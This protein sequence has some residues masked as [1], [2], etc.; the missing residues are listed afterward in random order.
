MVHEMSL[1]ADERFLIIAVEESD[2]SVGFYDS[3]DGSQVA[4]VGVG[5]WPHEIAMSPDRTL[6]YVTNFGVKDYDERIGKPGASISIID[7]EAKCEIDRLYTFRDLSEFKRFQSPHG[8]VVS[9]DGCTAYVNVESDDHI[10]L[11]DLTKPANEKRTPSDSWLLTSTTSNFDSLPDGKFPVP[12]GTHNM[13]LSPDEATLWVVS[14][15]GGVTEYCVATRKPMRSF[16]CNGAVRGLTYTRDHNYLIASASNEVCIVDPTT[17]RVVRRFSNLGI[18]QVLYS[19]PTPDGRYILSPAVWE[20]QLVRIDMHSGATERIIVG[21]DPI[22]VLTSPRFPDETYAYVTHGRSRYISIVD[23]ANF[24][25]VGRIETNGGPNGISWAPYSERPTR[26]KLVFGAC[27]PMSGG[28]AVEGQDL[29]LGYQF[30]QELVNDAGGLRAGA[31]VYEVDI[32]FRDSYSKTGNEVDEPQPWDLPPEDRTPPRE[33]SIEVATRE[34]VEKQ[35]VCCVFGG[36]PSPPNLHSARVAE[37][38]KVPFLTASGA[39]GLI[40]EQGFRYTFGLMTSAKGFLNETF[41]FFQTL[42]APPKSFVFLSCIDPAA[43]QDAETTAE[44]AIAQLGMEVLTSDLWPNRGANGV[45]LFEHLNASFDSLLRVVETLNPDVIAVTGHLPESI[46]SVMAAKVRRLTPTAFVF[47]VGPA[48]PQ[49]SQSL[50]DDSLEMIGSAMWSSVQNSAGHDRF[51]RPITFEEAFFSRFSRYPSYL[52]AGAMACGLAIEEAIRISESADSHEIQKSLH[53][54]DFGFD[55]FYSR[56]EF[57]RKGLN[58]NRPLL[59]IQLQKLQNE[60][61]HV[62]LWPRDL[63]SEGQVIWPFSGWINEA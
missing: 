27:I 49:F 39:A 32:V 42:A 3:H 8:I 15:A 33:N 63:A 2:S 11:Y 7:V 37:S 12:S 56:I 43:R 54:I 36:Y 51:I 30:W 40:Y 19:Q 34:L 29:R 46:S 17:L 22:H 24:A 23:W 38:L 6:A 50:G 47:S 35:G 1:T 58:S 62:G 44:F 14:G 13:L 60:I 10:L 21:S 61:R 53:S 57:D 48:I 59:T 45:L 41:R 4:R 20:G 18:R 26:K 9:R 52:A 31:D 5:Y 28:S 16:V 25:E 55:S